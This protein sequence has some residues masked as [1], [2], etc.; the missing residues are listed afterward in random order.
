MIGY[1]NYSFVVTKCMAEKATF[2][3]NA[4]YKSKLNMKLE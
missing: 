1:R 2:A 4:N 3:K